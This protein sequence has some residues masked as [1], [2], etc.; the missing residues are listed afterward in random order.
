MP[1]VHR[2]SA[3]IQQIVTQTALRLLGFAVSIY[4]NS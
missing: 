3:K 1:D 2:H 4:T